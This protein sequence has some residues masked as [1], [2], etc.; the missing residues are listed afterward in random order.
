MGSQH[1]LPLLIVLERT[2]TLFGQN[3]LTDVKLDWK[4]LSGLNNVGPLPCCPSTHQETLGN[5]TLASVLEKY[6]ELFQPQLGCYNRDPVVL[7]ESKEAKF[8]KDRPVPYVLQSKVKSALLKMEKYDVIERVTSANSAAPIVVVDKKDSE[9]FRV[10][11]GFSVTCNASA[12]VETYPMPQIGLFA[13]KRF[14]N[15]IHSDP[16]IFRRIMDN[17]LLDIPKAVSRLDDIILVAGLDEEDHLHTL[18][19]ALGRLP[20]A[21]FRLNKAK[22]KFFLIISCLLGTY[23]WWRGSTP[24]SG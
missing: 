24:H 23:D 2:G 10:C 8:H 22:C 9:D 1:T 15:G 17:L 19:L 7:N 13:F 20:N 21:G 12:R 3:W 18:S 16:A 4:K 11:G 5:Q 14:P 6:N